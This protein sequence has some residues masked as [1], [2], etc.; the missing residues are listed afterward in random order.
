MEQLYFDHAATTPI[1]EEVLESMLPFLKGTFGNPSSVYSYGRQARTALEGAREQVA[2]LLSASPREIIFTG[3]GTEGDNF[4]LKGVAYSLLHK[5]NHIITTSIEHHAVLDS[6]HFLEKN[7][8][9]VTYLGVDEEGL[10]SLQEL[11]EAITDKTIL[12]SVMHGNNEVGTL[13][14]IEAIGEILRARGVLFH[15]DAVQTIGTLPMD[16]SKLP[17]DLLTLSAHKFY[18]PKGVGA[19]YVR[20]KTPL[21][22]LLHGGGQEYKRRAGTENLA[23]IVGLA[24]ALELAEQERDVVVPRIMGLRDR[25][26]QGLK[27]IP[28]MRVN[29]SITHR[30][31]NNVNVCFRYIE[32]ESLLLNLDMYGIAA[33]SGSACT[34]GSLEPSH[35]LLAMGLSHEIAHGSL[36]LTVGKDTTEEEV[37]RVLEVV[38]GI[39]HRLREMSPLYVN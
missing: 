30:L 39:V 26:L 20:R 7:G 28:H 29:G 2:A 37:D 3:G 1:R 34:S 14:S 35:V 22:P 33:S 25:L 6:A 12:V 23:G 31:P 36:R 11:E 15:T 21:E 9:R 38:P 17:V 24:K 19:L 16:L 4:A 13:Q 5:G 10:I 18:G 27:A 8:F 32:G